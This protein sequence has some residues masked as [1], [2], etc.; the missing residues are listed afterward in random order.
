MKRLG[1]GVPCL[2][3]GSIP[4]VTKKMDAATQIAMAGA[5]ILNS[6]TRTDLRCGFIQNRMMR[7]SNKTVIAPAA[8][9]KSSTEAKTN[10]SETERLALVDGTLTVNDPVS[11]VSVARTNHCLPMGSTYSE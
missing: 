6:T 8:A 11:S 4:E 5:A 2:E 1:S 9:P 3:Y 10:V 7:H